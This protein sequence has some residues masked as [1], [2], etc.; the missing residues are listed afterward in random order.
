MDLVPLLYFIEHVSK[1]LLS[2]VG[3]HRM[4][5]VEKTTRLTLS[6]VKLFLPL[7]VLTAFHHAP[8]FMIVSKHSLPV[9]P[10]PHRKCM[11]F[12]FNYSGMPLFVT[13][14]AMQL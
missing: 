9:N 5:T 4:A 1:Y 11:S 7:A 8:S 6:S 2:A 13:S 14:A 3:L 12:A 10:V